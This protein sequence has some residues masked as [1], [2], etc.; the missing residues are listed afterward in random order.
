MSESL[1][2]I[3]VATAP[4][5]KYDDKIQD[6]VLYDIPKSEMNE[7]IAGNTIVSAYIAIRPKQLRV[8]S[9]NH[10]ELVIFSDSSTIPKYTQSQVR[11]LK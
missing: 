2:A 11:S 4:A 7:G 1:P 6:E 3:G 10:A 8:T 9:T 5:I